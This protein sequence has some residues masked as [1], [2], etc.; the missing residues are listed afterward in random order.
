MADIYP[1]YKKSRISSLKSN[2]KGL[3]HSSSQPLF[4]NNIKK[5]RNY[6]LPYNLKKNNNNL[7]LPRLGDSFRI[8]NGK[9]KYKNDQTFISNSLNSSFR[10]DSKE[11][12]N[13]SRPRYLN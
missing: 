3:N 7:L 12:F 13:S 1:K 11:L 4:E 5:E 9:N 10:Q 8:E 6:L 2:H